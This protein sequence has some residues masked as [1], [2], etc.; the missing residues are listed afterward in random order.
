MRTFRAR[1]GGEDDLLEAVGDTEE[2]G[3]FD[4]VDLDTLRQVEGF[5]TTCELAVILGAVHVE[6][7][8]RDDDARGLDD[9]AHEE[10]HG[11]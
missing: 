3:P 9:T 2:E 5:L 1:L 8:A 6:L 10:E 7:V 4:L 11:E